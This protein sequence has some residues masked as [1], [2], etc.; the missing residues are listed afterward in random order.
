MKSS[1]FSNHER[2]QEREY[3]PTA[4]S[5]SSEVQGVALKELMFI[6]LGLQ[7]GAIRD[8]GFLAWY[9]RVG[10]AVRGRDTER[11]DKVG[12]RILSDFVLHF[13]FPD[14]D[15]WI[16]VFK[17][18]LSLC[19]LFCGTVVSAVGSTHLSN[20]VSYCC[21]VVLVFSLALHTFFKKCFG[22]II[23]VM[24]TVK[25]NHVLWIV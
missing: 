12:V 4:P 3:C 11:K 19:H 18:L 25:Q 20:P 24:L 21:C 5:K 10:V 7:R 8:R 23:F 13:V 1:L 9:P 6:F 17:V 14:A 15:K 2:V 16:N 22:R